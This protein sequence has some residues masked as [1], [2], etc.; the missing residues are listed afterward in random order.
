MTPRS[1]V[2]AR[3]AVDDLSRR[4]ARLARRHTAPEVTRRARGHQTKLQNLK[5]E[6][7]IS[8]V[9]HTKTFHPA[10]GFNI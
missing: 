2:R 4:R 5:V 7:A 3:V 6:T 8:E 10:I 9:R 1:R